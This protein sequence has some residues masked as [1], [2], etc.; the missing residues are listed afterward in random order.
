MA[1]YNMDTPK[2]LDIHAASPNLLGSRSGNRATAGTGALKARAKGERVL[3]ETRQQMQSVRDALCGHGPG[4]F[5]EHGELLRL[6]TFG[7]INALT[8]LLRGVEVFGR[9]EVLL[10]AYSINQRANFALRNLLADG[11]ILGALV[12]G[13]DTITWRDPPRIRE[14][15]E[16]A[17][18]F[19]DLV[20]FGMCDNHAKVIAFRPGDHGHHIVV[21]GSAN[22]ASNAR[23]EDY[24]MTNSPEGWDHYEGWM[25]ELARPIPDPATLENG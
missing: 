16:T 20:Q 25:R 9:V 10:A 19:P 3:Y 5:P 12:L 15:W 13:S 14:M 24:A 17:E 4:G 11:A 2:G 1:V 22:L 23:I 7:Q 6:T 8:I 18:R 21:T